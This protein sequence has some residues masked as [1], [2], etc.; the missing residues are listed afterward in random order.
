MF[1]ATAAI[2]LQHRSSMFCG[3][4][5]PPVG[6]RVL[7]ANEPY[8]TVSLARPAMAAS[9]SSVMSMARLKAWVSEVLNVDIPIGAVKQGNGCRYA[10]AW[11]ALLGDVGKRLDGFRRVLARK[12]VDAVRRLRATTP[13]PYEVPL[14]A[15][16]PSP[17]WVR[18]SNPREIC[19]P[20]MHDTL[21][22]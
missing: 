2:S 14:S 1:F 10:S 8:T 19:T 18:V 6:S 16:R 21:T 12:F 13:L 22:A 11:R 5:I 17:P 4:D 7:D 20:P 3:A 9:S 15:Q